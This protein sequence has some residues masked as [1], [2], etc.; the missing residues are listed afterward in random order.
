MRAGDDARSNRP[1]PAAVLDHVFSLLLMPKTSR[2]YGVAPHDRR[3]EI[4]TPTNRPTPMTYALAR[5]YVRS[6]LPVNIQA[7]GI[8]CIHIVVFEPS[9]IGPYTGGHGE[10]TSVVPFTVSVSLVLERSSTSSSA[11]LEELLPGVID[12][13]RFNSRDSAVVYGS[14]VKGYVGS[15]NV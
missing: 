4:G 12:I 6:D 3:W 7:R 11:K 5:R 15:A 2:P 10:R 9:F 13:D 14:Q 8:A 1:L